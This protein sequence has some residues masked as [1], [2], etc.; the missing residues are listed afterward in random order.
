MAEVAFGLFVVVP[1]AIYWAERRNLKKHQKEWRALGPLGPSTEQAGSTTTGHGSALLE[2]PFK[3]G[4]RLS[5]VD[6]LPPSSREQDGNAEEGVMV[7]D[8]FLVLQM[9]EHVHTTA[10]REGIFLTAMDRV[11]FNSPPVFLPDES[12]NSAMRI[13]V[14]L[15]GQKYRG[16]N[17]TRRLM[18]VGSLPVGQALEAGRHQLRIP[19]RTRKGLR[20]GFVRVTVTRE[21]P[22][23]KFFV[24]TEVDDYSLHDGEV[25]QR[26][27]G[28]LVVLGAGDETYLAVPE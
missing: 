14:F 22:L 21:L 28:P 13:Q 19:M 11:P 18:A 5:L 1:V 25:E 12:L 10:R 7:Y 17:D 8:P 26:G 15:Y 2:E 24:A 23:V 3:S 9:G 4:V 16:K 27:E 20:A 6:L